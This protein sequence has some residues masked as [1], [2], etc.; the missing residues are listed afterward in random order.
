MENWP[1]IQS[2]DLSL[3][4]RNFAEDLAGRL[5][6]FN[7]RNPEPRM[8]EEAQQRLQEIQEQHGDISGP[9]PQDMKGTFEVVFCLYMGSR[10]G[11]V[12]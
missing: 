4:A 10:Y 3:H 9:S 6:E 5:A 2:E 1:T 12:P 8:S 7:K 11:L